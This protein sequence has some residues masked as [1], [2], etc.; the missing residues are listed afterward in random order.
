MINSGPN[1]FPMKDRL[2]AQFFIAYLLKTSLHGT[3]TYVPT[4][5][6]KQNVYSERVYSNGSVAENRMTVVLPRENLSRQRRITY[7]S[8]LAG[9]TIL[10]MQR[11]AS[12][13]THLSA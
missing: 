6:Q 13:S 1:P 10:D 8:L 7:I 9:T 3:E 5:I 11:P 12:T 2:A 4:G